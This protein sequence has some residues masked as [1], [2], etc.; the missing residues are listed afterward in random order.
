[1]LILK[2]YLSLIYLKLELD[3]DWIKYLELE[4][5]ARNDSGWFN[6]H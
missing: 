2:M 4:K 6:C 3:Y 1:M 5:K